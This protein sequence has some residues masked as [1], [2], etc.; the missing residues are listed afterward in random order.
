MITH[1][2]KLLAAN[3]LLR[4]QLLMLASC[5]LLLQQYLSGFGCMDATSGGQL[6]KMPDRSGNNHHPVTYS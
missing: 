5:T 2:L 3:Q 6:R 1:I 4:R